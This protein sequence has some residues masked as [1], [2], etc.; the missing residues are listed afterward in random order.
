MGGGGRAAPLPVEAAG[1]RR[2]GVRRLR[3]RL[4]WRQAAGFPAVPASPAA[5]PARIEVR[6][7]R[8]GGPERD[9]PGGS[10]APPLPLPPTLT[11]ELCVG[12]KKKKKVR[13]FRNASRGNLAPCEVGRERRW[14]VA[15]PR[16]GAKQRRR[17]DEQCPPERPPETALPGAESQTETVVIVTFS[18]LRPGFDPV[19]GRTPSLTCSCA[20]N[21]SAS[22]G[23]LRHR[24]D[25]LCKLICSSG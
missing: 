18:R 4:G 17:G 16:A 22:A 12:K 25:L 11:P 10:A 6:G 3:R 15:V 13:L 21:G 5:A 24:L 19:D 1:V 20:V 2:A 14:R 9:N 7:P 23:R 8:P